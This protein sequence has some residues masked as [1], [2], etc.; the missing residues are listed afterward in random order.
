MGTHLH[1][2]HRVSVFCR[3]RKSG[4]VSS[5]RRALYLGVGSF[6]LASALGVGLA[7][8][9]YVP[10]QSQQVGGKAPPAHYREVV[11]TYCIGCHNGQ[12]K[13]AGLELDKANVANPAADAET[14]EK[15]VRKLRARA[16]PPQGLARPDEATYKDIVTYL[17][18]SLDRAAAAKLNP[19]RPATH[20]VNR[21]EYANAIRDLLAVD[22]D[23]IDLTSVLPTDDAGYGFDN[24]A[25]VLTVSPLLIEGYLSAARKVSRVAVGDRKAG[26]TTETYDLP[27][28]LIQNDRMGEDLSLG[29]RGGM[30][31][32]HHF[33]LDA[34][35]TIRIRLQKNG[36][37][38]RSAPNTPVSSTSASTASA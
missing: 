22:T 25:D 6:A 18:T 28:F 27:R 31:V 19:G 26:P 32:R 1:F 16:M 5:A 23:A 24:I 36:Y 20:R 17:E 3:T 21:T 29:S 4:S 10:A 35:Y 9:G 33:P 30:A 37:C 11:D 14:F 2:R 12:L 38:T 7:G 8:V 15:V 13:T 34:E